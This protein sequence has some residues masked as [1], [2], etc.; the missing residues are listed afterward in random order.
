[1]GLK[2]SKSVFGSSFGTQQKTVG[3]VV[4]GLK[5]HLLSTGICL[6]SK[7]SPHCKETS[8]LRSMLVP[9]VIYELV[10]VLGIY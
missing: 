6:D 1:M 10:F 7:H 5:H 2:A 4:D 3:I 8:S 9:S